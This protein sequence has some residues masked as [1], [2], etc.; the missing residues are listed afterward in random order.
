MAIT[1]IVIVSLYIAFI[2]FSDI[3]KIA[4][5]IGEIDKKYLLLSIGI[6]F[7]VAITTATRWHIYLKQIGGKIPFLQSLTYYLAGYVFV[8]SPAG[9]GEIIRSPFLKRD[10]GI[11]V[12]KTAS[13]VVI[14]R[15]Y[16]L[17]GITIVISIGLIYSNFE[18]SIIVLPLGL[19]IFIFVIMKNRSI[20]LGTINKLSQLKFIAKMLPNG[21]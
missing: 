15:F 4:S 7:L 14:E 3:G 19:C 20:F 18:K 12:S 17:L 2:I 5:T 1:I 13:I 16:D 11:P 9:A 6:W 10:F 21:E 8:F